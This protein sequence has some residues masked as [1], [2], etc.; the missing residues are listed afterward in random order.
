[1]PMQIYSGKKVK[2]DKQLLLASIGKK[3]FASFGTETY[4]YD[5]CIATCTCLVGFLALNYNQTSK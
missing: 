5:H 1:M 2:R 4:F 3:I